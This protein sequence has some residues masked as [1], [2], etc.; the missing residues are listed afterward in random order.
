MIVF[1]D[2]NTISSANSIIALPGFRTAA[3]PSLGGSQYE[4]QVN[5][6]ENVTYTA[7]YTESLLGSASARLVLVLTQCSRKAKKVQRLFVPSQMAQ[8]ESFPS[9]GNP[10]HG[11]ISNPFPLGEFACLSLG[12]AFLE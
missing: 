5:A 8:G 11:S 12:I 7:C 3:P 6:T 4:L 10:S 1:V 9:F 2:T